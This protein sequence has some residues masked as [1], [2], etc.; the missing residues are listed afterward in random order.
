MLTV[1]QHLGVDLFARIFPTN[2]GIRFEV[3]PCKHLFIVLTTSDLLLSYWLYVG[4]A[5]TIIVFILPTSYHSNLGLRLY[6]LFIFLVLDE[7]NCWGK[8]WKKMLVKIEATIGMKSMGLSL[9]G[10]LPGDAAQL[11]SQW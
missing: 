7:S 5:G 1:Q 4:D 10:C 8:S 11:S 9:T 6:C 2:F 3:F